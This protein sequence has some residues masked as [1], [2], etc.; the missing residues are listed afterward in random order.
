MPDISMR[1][2]LDIIVVEGGMATMLERYG[3]SEAPCP[4]LFNL[5]EPDLISEIHRFFKLAGAQCAVSN[6]FGAGADRLALQGIEADQETLC[7]E[8]VRLA[9]ANKPQHV[10]ADMGPCTIRAGKPGT[11]SYDEAYAVYAHQSEL[12]AKGGPDAI[13]IETMADIDD[14]LCALRAAKASCDLPVIVSCSFDASGKTSG[15]QTT[16][17]EAAEALA[18]A[19]ADAIGANCLL[20]PEEIVSV[21]AELVRS[22]ALPVLAMPDVPRPSSRPVK[23]IADSDSP[24]HM[25]VAAYRLRQAGVQLIGTCCGST[26]AY[27]GAIFAAVGGTDVIRPRG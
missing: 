1:F 3:I 5:T 27:T 6:T 14:A 13:F 4:E 10:L 22:T 24:D 21:A 19:G 15:S 9:K 8:G 12:L 11:S 17:E 26:P 20:R 2:G 7:A 23:R 18:R 25:A 16:V